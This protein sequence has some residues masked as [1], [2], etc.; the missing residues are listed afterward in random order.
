MDEPTP[1]RSTFDQAKSLEELEGDD[2][3]DPTF[4]SHLVRECHR[5]RRIPL[6]E[7]STENL[8]ILIGQQIGLRYLLPMALNLLQ[9]DPFVAGD[10]Y[11]GDL[12]MSVLRAEASFWRAHPELWRQADEIA[13][14][15]F[16]I[17]SK[18][19]EAD[20][21]DLPEMLT[22]AYGLFKKAVQP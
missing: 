10:F 14:S 9:A 21:Q 16:T 12:L 2:W 18:S 8:R 5:S 17:A 1:I 6:R 20:D 19:K 15:A 13:Q 7:L 11:R 4:D 3:G 22:G